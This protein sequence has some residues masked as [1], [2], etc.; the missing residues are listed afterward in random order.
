MIHA[1]TRPSSNPR[2]QASVR[3]SAPADTTIATPLRLHLAK[4]A[5]TSLCPRAH[6]PGWHSPALGRPLRGAWLGLVDAQ[7]TPVKVLAV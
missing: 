5:C 4:E 7:R 3:K 1:Q 6:Y 2:K